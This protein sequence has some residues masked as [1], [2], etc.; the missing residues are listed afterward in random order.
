MENNVEITGV[1]HDNKIIG[2]DSNNESTELG[3]TGAT[4]KA[5]EMTLI[6]EAITET[7]RDIAEGNDILT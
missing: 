1:R 4:D 3:G 5:D 7:E 6:D 2:V